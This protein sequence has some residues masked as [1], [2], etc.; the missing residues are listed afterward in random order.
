MVNKAVLLM[1]ATI[2]ELENALKNHFEDDNW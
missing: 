2:L 1:N